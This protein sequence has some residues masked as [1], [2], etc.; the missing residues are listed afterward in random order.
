MKIGAFSFISMNQT[1]KFTVKPQYLSGAKD[2]FIDYVEELIDEGK[3]KNEIV[4]RSEYWNWEERYADGLWIQFMYVIRF[5][6]QDES[7]GFEKTDEAIE[8]AVNLSF[9][10]MGEWPFDSMFQFAKFYFQS[11]T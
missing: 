3:N 5:W 4:E 2:A 6:L 10:L 8:K 7:D 1:I 9:D 11:S